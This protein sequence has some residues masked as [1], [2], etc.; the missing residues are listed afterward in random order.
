MLLLVLSSLKYLLWQGLSIRGHEDIESN[1]TQLLLLRTESNPGLQEFINA[2]TYLS[3]DIVNEM[4]SLMG[5]QVRNNLLE[6]IRKSGMFSLIADEATDVAHKEQLCISI[7]WVDDTFTIHETPIELIQI[8]KTDS[9]TIATEILSCL[10]R[11]G[12][13]ITQCRGQA[14]DGA[15]NMS[16]HINGVAAKIQKSSLAQSLCIV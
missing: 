6:D 10:G 1:L 15:S 8:S 16:G 3:G 7:R 12:L 2:K 13:P 14:Y 11:L 9:E 4:I 5:N